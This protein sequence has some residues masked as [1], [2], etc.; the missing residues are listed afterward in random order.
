MH[1]YLIRHAESEVNLPTFSDPDLLDLGLTERG[2]RQAKALADWLPNR[3]LQPDILY[4]STLLRTRQTMEPIER[5]FDMQATYDH[6]LR[7]IGHNTVSGEPVERGMA[8][9]YAEYWASE[10]PFASITNKVNGETLIHFRARIGLFLHDLL[11]QRASQVVLVVC[12]G[13]VIDTF[14][15]LAYNVGPFRNCEVWTSNSGITHLQYIQHPGRERW[16]LHY[17]NR[18]EHLQG[19]GGLGLTASGEPE[20]WQTDVASKNGA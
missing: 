16:R 9:S 20:N 12:H 11:E 13:F 17:Q 18:I 5:A 2:Q 14:L 19:I 4:S 1:L 7:E 8:M 15:D 3:I 6:R 10:R